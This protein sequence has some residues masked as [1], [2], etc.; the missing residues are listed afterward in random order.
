MR[1]RSAKYRPSIAKIHAEA[2]RLRGIFLAQQEARGFENL[3]ECVTFTEHLTDHGF[4]LHLNGKLLDGGVA[5]VKKV[6]GS[7]EEK[8]ATAVNVIDAQTTQADKMVHAMHSLGIDYVDGPVDREF[9]DKVVLEKL[10][11]EDYYHRRGYDMYAHLGL[12]VTGDSGFFSHLHLL[13]WDSELD[14]HLGRRVVRAFEVSVPSSPV[15]KPLSTADE[16]INRI[17]DYFGVWD[18]AAPY[19]MSNVELCKCRRLYVESWSHRRGPGNGGHQLHF[20][21]QNEG[22]GG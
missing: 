13:Q 2:V 6:E 11:S 14:D 7:G 9:I 5:S 19:T 22:I 12:G 1:V 18:M 16:L 20:D 15:V 21:S 3:G 10:Y 17:A 4:K 8:D